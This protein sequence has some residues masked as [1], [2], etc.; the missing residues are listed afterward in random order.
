MTPNQLVFS[1]AL[2]L[3]DLTAFPSQ[4]GKLCVNKTLLL[5]LYEP[6]ILIMRAPQRVSR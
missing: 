3:S 6:Q 5:H 2:L 1:I 4:T